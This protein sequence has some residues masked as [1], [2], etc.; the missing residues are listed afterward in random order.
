MPVTVISAARAWVQHA[1]A[2]R[3][4]A[5]LRQSAAGSVYASS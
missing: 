2:N 3:G 4:L 5:L 1:A